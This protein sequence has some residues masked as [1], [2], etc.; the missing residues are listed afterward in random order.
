MEDFSSSEPNMDLSNVKVNNIPDWEDDHVPMILWDD[1]SET[2][3][4]G[5]FSQMR[6]DGA[7]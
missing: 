2:T 6:I 4:S 5:V 1:G 3:D 7:R